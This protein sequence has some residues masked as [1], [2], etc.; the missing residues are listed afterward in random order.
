MSALGL[1]KKVKDIHTFGFS[2]SKLSKQRFPSFRVTSYS[3]LYTSMQGGRGTCT[4]GSAA[5]LVPSIFGTRWRQGLIIRSTKS[6]TIKCGLGLLRL[7]VHFKI[8]Q[9]V[10]PMERKVV[11]GPKGAKVRLS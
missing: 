11:G 8:S 7:Y 3:Q 4:S 1:D 9:M 5:I 6:L 10:I 2:R